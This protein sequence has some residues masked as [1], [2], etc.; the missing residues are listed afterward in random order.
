M[1]SDTLEMF[2]I[3]EVIHFVWSTFVRSTTKLVFTYSEK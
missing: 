1:R 2:S 3:C